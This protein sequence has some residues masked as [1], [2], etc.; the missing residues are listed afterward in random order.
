M[1]SNNDNLILWQQQL[2]YISKTIRQQTNLQ[3]RVTLDCGLKE[4]IV[5]GDGIDVVC[6]CYHG[7]NAMVLLNWPGAQCVCRKKPKLLQVQLWNLWIRYVVTLRVAT[8]IVVSIG[9]CTQAT[10]FVCHIKWHYDSWQEQFDGM[11]SPNKM[12]KMLI[13][14]WY[15]YSKYTNNNM[16]SDTP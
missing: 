5:N 3:V 12:S 14:I 9:V 16:M 2:K 10:N 7:F 8:V 6:I 13:L 15:W 4:F 11:Q 1:S